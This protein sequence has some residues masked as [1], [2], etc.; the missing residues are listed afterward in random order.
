[1]AIYRLLHNEAGADTIA[2][3]WQALSKT[4]PVSAGTNV[5]WPPNTGHFG[6]FYQARG[7]FQS[8]IQ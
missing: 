4:Y 2:R 1:M 3:Q 7:L 6:F 8:T 5:E